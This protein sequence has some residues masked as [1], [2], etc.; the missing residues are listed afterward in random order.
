ME[1]SRREIREKKD[2]PEVESRDTKA[3]GLSVIGELVSGY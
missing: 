2:D 3:R 1:R